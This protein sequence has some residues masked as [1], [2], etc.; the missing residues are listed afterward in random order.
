MGA[1]QRLATHPDCDRFDCHGL[2]CTA[3]FLLLSSLLLLAARTP[4]LWSGPLWSS[5]HLRSTACCRDRQ[6][7]SYDQAAAICSSVLRC[8]A[9]LLRSSSARGSSHHGNLCG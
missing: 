7:D 2:S 8:G 6:V 5:R 9:A 3:L 4:A 1:R